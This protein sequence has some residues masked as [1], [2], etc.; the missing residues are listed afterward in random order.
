MSTP[1]LAV[2]QTIIEESPAILEKYKNKY[3][4]YKENVRSISSDIITKEG[5]NS[6]TPPIIIRIEKDI[7]V[8][9]SPIISSVG[10]TNK[11]GVKSLPE[12]DIAS[13]PISDTRTSPGS[14][15]RSQPEI[16]QR[17]N[18]AQEISQTPI[19]SQAQT[20]ELITGQ[21]IIQ[22]QRQ[23][24][25]QIQD[26]ELQ[27]KVPFV[28]V[29]PREDKKKSEGNF[30]IEVRKKGIFTK[31][32]RASDSLIE[33][34]REARN[35]LETTEA[36]SYRILRNG[37][38]QDVNPGPGFAR[39]KRNSKVIIEPVSNRI[40][41]PGEKKEITYKGNIFSRGKAKKAFVF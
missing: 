32:G 39:S 10:F 12:A 4:T 24:T 14:I 30:E 11:P 16:D 28:P 35:I 5:G 17:A 40:N 6:R 20:S 9:D 38:V 29:L 25:R 31:T 13:R 41:T 22:Q 23:T 21:E 37:E 36:A 18:S 15:T 7:S 19:S 2:I 34:E 26:P 8:R 1:E 3:Q 33:A 27:R